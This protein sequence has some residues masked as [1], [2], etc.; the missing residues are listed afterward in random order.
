MN[1]GDSMLP[2]L[3]D[4]MP[5]M[6]H[7]RIA[8]PMLPEARATIEQHGC[9]FSEEGCAILLT[10]PPGTVKREIYPRLVVTCNYR[11]YFPDGYEV[12]ES[13]D[14]HRKISLLFYRPEP[15]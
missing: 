8:G 11:V 10:Y 13:Y 1:T 9:T 12:I 5:A 4:P 2:I 15:R 7:I 14:R 6:D 3:G